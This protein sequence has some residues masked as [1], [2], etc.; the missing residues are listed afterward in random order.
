MKKKVRHVKILA[1]CGMLRHAAACFKTPMCSS[2]KQVLRHAAACCGCTSLARGPRMVTCELSRVGCCLRR[3][4]Q[5]ISTCRSQEGGE[6]LSRAE[7]D[8]RRLSQ[9]VCGKVVLKVRPIAGE[10]RQH[11]RHCSY[12]THTAKN[13]RLPQPPPPLPLTHTSP[14]WT[15][16]PT[17]CCCGALLEIRNPWEMLGCLWVIGDIRMHWDA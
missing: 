13:D 11:H 4:Q 6:S 17:K 8:P 3:C 16:P 10:R 5:Q 14:L 12:N 15:P 9:K 7:N 1:R 2:K